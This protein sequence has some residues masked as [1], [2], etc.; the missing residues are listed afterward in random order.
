[1]Y[2]WEM[3]IQFPVF[4]SAPSV[5]AFWVLLY[6]SKFHVERLNVC[7]CFGTAAQPFTHSSL[8]ESYYLLG[9][10]M[11]I[12]NRWI[13][14][15]VYNFHDLHLKHLLYNIDLNTLCFIHYIIEFLPESLR[16]IL[17]EINLKTAWR[18]NVLRKSIVI[19]L[20]FNIAQ[21]WF[22]LQLKSFTQTA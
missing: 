4:K 2:F 19:S 7:Y 10:V 11:L 21:I 18:W 16:I 14:L 12:N 17:I 3:R 20:N 15:W 9:L 6:W 5:I 1:M 8:A 13:Y 22:K